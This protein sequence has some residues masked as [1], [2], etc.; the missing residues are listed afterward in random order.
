[1]CSH[2]QQDRKL[3]GTDLHLLHDDSVYFLC[4]GTEMSGHYFA[5]SPQMKTSGA[6]KTDHCC[7]GLKEQT[8]AATPCPSH[9]EFR[10]SKVL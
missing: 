3:L 6:Q 2:H 10:R 1:M 7:R 8:F 9:R 5:L 4:K